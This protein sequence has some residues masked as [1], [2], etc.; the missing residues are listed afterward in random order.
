MNS[1]IHVVEEFNKN[2]YDIIIGSDEHEIIGDESNGTAEDETEASVE[3]NGASAGKKPRPSKAR[4][5][6]SSKAGNKPKD[7]EFGISRGIDFQRVACVLNFDLPSSPTS[8]LHRIGRTARAGRT[9]IAFSFAIPAHE[10]GRHKPTSLPSTLHDPKVLA[11]IIADQASRGKA[12][13]DYAF[14]SAQIDAFRYRASDALKLVTRKAIRE[15]RTRELRQ[16]LITSAR[17]K[18]HFDENPDDLR[19]LTARHDAPSGGK[20][21]L[22]HLKQVPDYLL[23]AKDG[24][25]SAAT[26]DIG[27]V[28]PGPSEDNK[29]RKLRAAAAARAKGRAKAGPGR[30]GKMDPLR[31]FSAKGR[32]RKK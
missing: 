13:T 6:T 3:S 4:S 17:L 9:G 22:A 28:G 11:A 8:Y 21:M 2:V 24:I 16:E 30:R 7:K 14:D 29:R 10:Q 1:R 31:S 25:Q 15:A 5:S 18:R 32:G 26:R 20:P 19:G 23:P 27:F 12:V